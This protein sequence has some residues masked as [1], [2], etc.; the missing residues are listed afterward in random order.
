MLSALIRFKELHD[1]NSPL[2]EVI[3]IFVSAHTNGIPAWACE[4]LCAQMHDFY[5]KA[6]Q[7]DCNASSSAQNISPKQR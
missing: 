2:E 5:R 6:M 7:V 1:E 3:P 4:N